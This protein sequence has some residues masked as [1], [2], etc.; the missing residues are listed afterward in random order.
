MATAAARINSSAKDSSWSQTNRTIFHARLDGTLYG[1]D[2]ANGV[3]A[4]REFVHPGLH[5]RF[6]APPE[7][8]INHEHG[9]VVAHHDSG[10]GFTFDSTEITAAQSPVAYLRETWAR[11]Q[12]S[13]EGSNAFRSNGLD[14]A[15]G[16]GTISQGNQSVLLRLTAIRAS[17]RQIYR[18]VF[19]TPTQYARRIDPQFQDTARSLERISGERLAQIRPLRVRARRATA[20]DQVSELASALPYGSDNECG[21]A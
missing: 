3:F 1:I 9:H 14:A 4:G 6:E 8:R 13:L 2:P 18:F 21:S 19:G 12:I 10:A 17:D 16:W 20:K 5:A 15:T 7:F 11:D